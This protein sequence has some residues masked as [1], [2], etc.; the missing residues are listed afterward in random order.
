M[1][2][3]QKKEDDEMDIEAD[4]SKLDFNLPECNKHQVPI[5]QDGCW[6]CELEEVRKA[7]KKVHI[8]V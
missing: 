8:A 3:N 1:F 6:V 7:G 4:I 2:T 5:D